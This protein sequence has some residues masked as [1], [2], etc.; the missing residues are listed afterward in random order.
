MEPFLPHLNVQTNSNL[1]F[2]LLTINQLVNLAKENNFKHLVIADYQPYEIINFFNLCKEKEIKPIW[3]IKIFFREKLE[4]KIYSVTIYPQ[5]SKGYK[6]VIQKLFFADSPSDRVF[7]LEFI[8]VSLSKNCLIIFEAQNLQEIIFFAN[9]WINIKSTRKEIN[10]DNL[11]IGF[12]FFLLSPGSNIPS[13]VIPLLLP[14][15]AIKSL[16]KEETS[17]VDSWKSTSFN[18]YFFSRDTKAEHLAY[19][20]TEDYFSHCTDDKTFYQLLLIQWQTFLNKINLNVS[21]RGEKPKKSKKENNLLLLKS[22]CWQKLLS[23]RKEK[24]ENYQQILE[25]ELIIIEKFN[26]TNY[27]LIFS[28]AVKHLKK[29]EI[30]VGPGRGSSVSSLVTYLLGIT[31]VDPLQHQLFFERFLNEKRKILPDIDLDVEDQGEIFNYLQQKYPKKQVARIITK[32]RIG[33]KT[34]CKEVAKIYRISEIKLKEIILLSGKNLDNLKL[35]NS[36]LSYKDFFNLVEKIQNLYY[37][38]SIHPAGIVIAEQTLVGLVPLKTENDYLITLFEENN[39]SQ[40]GLKK[41]DF[42]SLKET[43][44]FIRETREILSSKKINLPD[45]QEVNL[46]DEKTWELLNNFLLTGLF[47]LDTP[48]ARILFNKFRPKNFSELVIF[49][50]LNRPGT[51]KKAE[52]ISQKKLNKIKPIFTSQII[53]KILLET[54]ESI[55]FEEQVSQIFAFI[56]NCS[57]AEAEVKRRELTKKGLEKEFFNNAE[58]KILPYESKLIYNQIISSV[59]YTF[60]KAHAVGY[61]YLTYYIAYLKANFFP[62]LII[63]F[64]NKGKEKQLSYL[65]EAFFNGFQIKGPDINYSEINWIKK[66][67]FLLMGFSNLKE[68]RTEFFQ[69]LIEE[70]EKRGKYKDWE[71]FL[72]RTINLWEKVENHIFGEWIKSG[73]FNSLKIDS[74][75]LLNKQTEFSRYLRIRRTIKTNSKSLPFLDLKIGKIENNRLLNNQREYENLGLYIS[76][77]S[78]WKEIEQKAEYKIFSLLDILKNIGEYNNQEKQISIYAIIFRI[79][80][81]DEKNYS[82]LLQNIRNSFKLNIDIDNYEKN[83]EIL[84]NHNELLFDLK[85]GIKNNTINSLICEKISKISNVDIV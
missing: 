30:I 35:K 21:F 16:N 83:K 81:I 67:K 36:K 64:L 15:F 60:N 20:N 47:Q 29:K 27:L 32:K 43:L 51:K 6:E 31:N 13:Q 52:E 84:V 63:Y 34:A 59:G 8:L 71:D 50:S 53:K 62:E 11:F 76:Y 54:Y 24:E 65:Q 28:D 72:N 73:L 33:W 55:I 5:N 74:E 38:T 2:S 78:R 69:G 49:L 18:R 25:K 26:Y 1:S 4:S 66:E 58:K 12:N 70:R 57:F 46:T 40:L 9:Q 14:F 22:K 37:D 82:L 68:Y 39:F 44:G 45:Y 3:G 80:K 41:Y 75:T 48:S 17:L 10:S 85:I 79:E 77:F 19:L 61:G 42:L 7:L 23:L 56:Y